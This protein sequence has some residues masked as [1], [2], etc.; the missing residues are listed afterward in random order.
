MDEMAHRIWNR[1]PG[2]IP[3][4]GLF[5]PS[6]TSVVPFGKLVDVLECGELMKTLRLRA[7]GLDVVIEIART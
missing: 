6:R 5:R 7:P 2:L 3:F 1:S 4:S